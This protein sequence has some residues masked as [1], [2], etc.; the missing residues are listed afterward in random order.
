MPEAK[1]NLKD[2]VMYFLSPSD[3]K[4]SL[5]YNAFVL[6]SV[7]FSKTFHIALFVYFTL[8][9]GIGNNKYKYSLKII[10]ETFFID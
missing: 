1:L 10:A 4:H 9:G 2:H 8:S 3:N 6:Y 5:F 7:A